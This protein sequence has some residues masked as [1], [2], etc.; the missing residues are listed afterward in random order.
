MPS[1]LTMERV[2]CSDTQV[3]KPIE[4]SNFGKVSIVDDELV[5]S[6]TTTCSMGV[7]ASPSEQVH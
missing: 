5:V 2:S 7:G 3:S 1:V 6:S 4:G